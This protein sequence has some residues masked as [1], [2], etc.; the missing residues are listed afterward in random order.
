MRTRALSLGLPINHT[1]LRMEARFL[2][3]RLILL[4]DRLLEHLVNG[5]NADGC[6][7]APD[8]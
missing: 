1:R 8:D 4:L 6:E 2:T 3:N 5:N 7:D